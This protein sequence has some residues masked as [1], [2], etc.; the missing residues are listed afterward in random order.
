MS[1]E[2]VRALPASEI[3]MW[4][5]YF[6]VKKEEPEEKPQSNELDSFRKM[7]KV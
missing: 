5:A 3:T 1:L 7:I 4:I 6:K 2:Q